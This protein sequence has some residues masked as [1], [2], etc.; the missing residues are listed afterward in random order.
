[1]ILKFD[2]RCHYKIAHGYHWVNAGAFPT[3][4]AQQCRSQG[5]ARANGFSPETGTDVRTM[6][7]PAGKVFGP[8][9]YA[10][11]LMARR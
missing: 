4:I 1:M 11:A 3:N 9:P 2:Q 8:E 7:D 6:K 10:A 5:P